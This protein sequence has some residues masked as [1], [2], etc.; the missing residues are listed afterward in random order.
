MHTR[1]Q[2]VDLTLHLDGGFSK[3]TQKKTILINLLGL[4]RVFKLPLE[5]ESCYVPLHAC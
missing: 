2:N 1:R 3:A 4:M 5:T